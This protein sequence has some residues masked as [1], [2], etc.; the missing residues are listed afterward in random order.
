MC[1][2]SGYGIDGVPLWHGT[3]GC[4]LCSGRSRSSH[5]KKGPTFKVKAKLGIS[6]LQNP[7]LKKSIQVRL[8][9]V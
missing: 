9:G 3:A 8:E 5:Q 4:V 2:L 6:I 1:G 7:L